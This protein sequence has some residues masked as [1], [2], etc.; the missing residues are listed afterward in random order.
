MLLI[1]LTLAAAIMGAAAGWL[2]RPWLEVRARQLLPFLPAVVADQVAGGATL[3]GRLDASIT[4]IESQIRQGIDA[5]R[6]ATRLQILREVRDG[7]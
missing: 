5:E 3:A 7:D 1:G 6:N 2:L 4:E